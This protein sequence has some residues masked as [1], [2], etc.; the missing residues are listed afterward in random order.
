MNYRNLLVLPPMPF[1]TFKD[2][3]SAPKSSSDACQTAQST[4]AATRESP[5]AFL[6]GRTNPAQ[7]VL[8]ICAAFTKNI[9]ATQ[10]VQTNGSA[11]IFPHKTRTAAT[12][13]C[14]NHLST[15][16]LTLHSNIGTVGSGTGIACLDC[17]FFSRVRIRNIV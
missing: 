10:M 12:L 5:F 6:S 4:K 16:F 3:V 14:S 2:A 17:F 15:R 13:L 1:H 7:P 9:T 8:P 11:S